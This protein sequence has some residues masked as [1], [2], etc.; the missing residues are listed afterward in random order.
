MYNLLDSH[1]TMRM[2]R[3]VGDNKD[4]L[5]LAFVFLFTFTGS[6]AIYYGDEIGLSGGGDPDCRRC[7]IW[8]EREQDLDLY[9][10]FKNIIRLR[11]ENP[12]FASVDITWLHTEDNFL[13]YRKEKTIVIVNN[14]DK[15][16]DYSF[17]ETL[18]D[19]ETKETAKKFTVKPYGYR[20]LK[21]VN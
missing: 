13:V 3:R 5:K 20:I 19:S 14:S 8:D 12:D 11:K 4:I 7:M 17:N 1:D 2:L 16:S 21:V 6:P 10:F 18:E 9:N 15:V